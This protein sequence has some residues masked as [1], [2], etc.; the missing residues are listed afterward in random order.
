MKIIPAEFKEEDH[1]LGGGPVQ[2]HMSTAYRLADNVPDLVVL[3]HQLYKDNLK[4]FNQ[5]WEETLLALGN[6]F[7][8]GVLE[9]LY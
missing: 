2:E 5:V 9:N 7:D 4:M 3:Q 8:E 1:F 6:D